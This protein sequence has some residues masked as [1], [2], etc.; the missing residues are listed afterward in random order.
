MGA[1]M[2]F[3]IPAMCIGIAVS[4][5]VHSAGAD[6]LGECKARCDAD[7]EFC[8]SQ[9]S[10]DSNDLDGQSDPRYEEAYAECH[11]TGEVCAKECDTQEQERLDREKQETEKEKHPDES[12]PVATPPDSSADVPSAVAPTDNQPVTP[13]DSGDGK[14][15]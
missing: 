6:E 14:N 5:F 10:F 15:Q 4:M 1:K 8:F 12:P 2:K 11:K 3:V 9:I 7:R 13:P